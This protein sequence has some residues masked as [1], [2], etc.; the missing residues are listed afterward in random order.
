M[1][2]ALPAWKAELDAIVGVRHGGRIAQVLPALEDL[3]RRFPGV[4]WIQLQLAWSSEAVGQA[5]RAIGH[6]ERAIALG[7]EGNAL[8]GALLGLGALLRLEGDTARALKVLQ[9]GRQQFPENREFAVF[10]SLALHDTGRPSEALRLA[11]ETLLE[12][13]DDIGLTAYQR[14]IRQHTARLQD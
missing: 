6:Y 11:L 8:S 14:L 12:T 9:D 3:D 1:D 13:S 5:S 2:P 4:P 10:L 7:L